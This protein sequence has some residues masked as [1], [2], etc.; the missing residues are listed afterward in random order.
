MLSLAASAI[1]ASR[2]KPAGGNP[3]GN[4]RRK[5]NL[6]FNFDQVARFHEA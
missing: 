4:R 2:V 6:T 3:A 1:R 5:R